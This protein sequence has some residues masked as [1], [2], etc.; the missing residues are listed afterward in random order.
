[1]SCTK[2]CPPF[3]GWSNIRRFVLVAADTWA[4]FVSPQ[5]FHQ[6]LR[7]VAHTGDNLHMPDTAGPARPRKGAWMTPKIL[8]SFVFRVEL[9]QLFWHGLLWSH[10]VGDGSSTRKY[11]F[12]EIFTRILCAIVSRRCGIAAGA[13]RGKRSEALDRSADGAERR[14][15]RAK[16]RKPYLYIVA[17]LHPLWPV[18]DL[19]RRTD[20]LRRPYWVRK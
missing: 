4:S 12:G 5:V 15:N 3:F 13:G 1:M 16:C 7:R 9:G 6:M 11:D 14:R 17:V 10:A 2:R 18:A 8:G 19:H 20:Q